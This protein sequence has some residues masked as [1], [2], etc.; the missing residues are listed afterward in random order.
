MKEKFDKKIFWIIRDL[1]NGLY[2]I[3]LLNYLLGKVNFTLITNRLYKRFLGDQAAVGDG[4]VAGQR[5]TDHELANKSYSFT[6]HFG[7]FFKL[8]LERPEVIVCEGFF[9]WSFY[10]LVYRIFFRK[11]KLIMLYERTHRT[12]RSAQIIRTLYRKFFLKICDLI[13][14]S[15]RASKKYVR[16]LDQKIT[17]EEGHMCANTQHFNL[18]FA[19]PIESNQIRCIFVGRLEERKGILNL[20]ESFLEINPDNLILDI[21]GSGSQKHIVEKLCQK[22]K[23]LDFLGSVDN[24]RLPEIFSKYQCLILPTIEDNWSLV[25]FEALS[26]GKL[27]VSSIANGASFNFKSDELIK[28]NPTKKNGCKI[29]I[30]KLSKSPYYKLE[31]IR[32]NGIKASRNYTLEKTGNNLARLINDV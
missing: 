19:T 9:R 28:F 25:G 5:F 23:N 12:E 8:F 1:S 2:R 6:F 17:I 21:I 4:F 7:L 14:C 24:E 22:S 26:A 31:S 30:N 20:L 32:L 18:N 11:S 3:D 10:A 15:G 27:F 16:S 13:V 29:V